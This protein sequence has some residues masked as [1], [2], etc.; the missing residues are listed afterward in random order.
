[1]DT[2]IE[3]KATE[4]G[5]RYGYVMPLARLLALERPAIGDPNRWM[6]ASDVGLG[7]EHV[8]ELIRLMAD[9]HWDRLD[10]ELP[11]VYA[12]VHAWRAL[13][14][15]RAE[16]AIPALIELLVCNDEAY[17]DWVA[18]EVPVV[19]GK[20]GS[21]S[22]PALSSYLEACRDDRPS[23]LAA[24]RSVAQIGM[25]HPEARERCVGILMATLE[26][27]AEN[28]PALNGFLVSD[29][30]DLDALD[31]VPLIAAAFD[32]GNVDES[33]LGDMEDVEIQ[34]GLRQERSTP[35]TPF[36]WAR[37]QPTATDPE[38]AKERRREQTAV[39]RNKA[40]RKQSDATRKKARQRK[41]KR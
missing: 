32:A 19:L 5:E 16:E 24:S 37:S 22:I 28:H 6:T 18:E 27:H 13:A 39:A 12:P 1:M 4:L 36:V 21:G 17:D 10:S 25:Q 23:C 29:L 7:T 20:I 2:E 14:D 33:I 41:K 15:L 38:S 26:R 11:E 40:K 8:P 30:V 35:A 31:A 3:A 9:P 34:L